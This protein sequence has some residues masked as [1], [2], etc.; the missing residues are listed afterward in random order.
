MLSK[1][2]YSLRILKRNK[3]IL[4]VNIVGLWVGLAVCLLLWVYID[5][6]LSY[7]KHFKN[8]A[9][10]SRLITEWVE[11]DK[12]EVF[13]INLR[14]AYTE[15]PAGIP[16]VEA[17]VQLYRSWET[18]IKVNESNFANLKMLYAD[19]TFFKVFDA[20]FVYGSENKPFKGS[21]SAII[22]T[23]LA[24]KAFGD[25][26]PLGK[27]IRIDN[28]D[29]QVSG[30]IKDFPATTHFNFQVLLPMQATENLL[31]LGGL[32]FYTYYLYAPNTN[33]L[34]VS[35]KI[36]SRYNKQLDDRFGEF[37][38]EF[39]SYIEPLEQ[40]HLFTKAE[41]DLSP[42]GNL[43]QVFLVALISFII[44]FMA[45]F[46]CVNLY[47]VFG[48]NRSKELG[49][50]KISGASSKSIKWQMLFE[51][52]IINGIALVL[53]LVLFYFVAPYFGNL[54]QRPI[55]F[56]A[57]FSLSGM[58]ALVFILFFSTALSG[59]YPAFV[60]SKFNSI[61]ILSGTVAKQKI[62]KWLSPSIV[63]GQFGMVVLL[64]FCLFSIND[65]LNF[66]KQMPLGFNPRNV[67]AFSGFN[68]NIYKQA[69]SL[70]ND[71]KNLPGVE[72][73]G[74]S[75]HTMGSGA[76]GQAIKKFGNETGSEISIDEFRVQPGFCKTYDL[77][78]VWG[79]FFK[80]NE[81]GNESVVILNRTA[82]ERLGIDNREN[83]RVDMFEFPMEVVGVVEDFM[84]HGANQVVQPMVLCCRDSSFWNINIRLNAFGG[85]DTRNQVIAIIQKYD[86][87]YIPT[88]SF[89]SER[90]DSFYAS[91][92]RTTQIVGFGS[93]VAIL[94]SLMGLFAITVY[95]IHRKYKE[96][97]IRKVLGAS[98]LKIAHL[99]LL[100]LGYWML[101][102]VLFA[103]PIG[104]LIIKR[105][106]SQYPAHAELNFAFFIL[107]ALLPLL[108]A[109]LTIGWHV[110][111]V[112]RHNPVESLRYE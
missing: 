24:Q 64:L 96:L 100:N 16:E 30:V 36:T 32:E 49:I 65:Q 19:T 109:L 23:S 52:L 48:Q 47:M 8:S 73:M 4:T 68:S 39:S 3:L 58:L 106:F 21:L 28:R 60:L 97:G 66:L 26:N 71:L 42:I 27:I 57:V 18:K 75:Q 99:V 63:I 7:D 76:S 22:T 33:H 12:K 69:Q 86:P 10:I 72:Q 53:A 93:L 59:L 84:Y 105:W 90:F 46:N 35:D 55:A 112:A 31:Y 95:N 89:I 103:W 81:L 111:K 101:I 88:Y 54:I 94:I 44:L 104:T 41:F 107:S 51:A 62:N 67:V 70:Q 50:R 102:A 29:F 13:P 38:A 85:S 92:K 43:K 61:E 56:N 98:S 91:E 78:L 83:N 17:S 45:I 87:D 20:S 110:L 5:H 80:P 77:K 34:D 108:L 11:G 2:K 82:A 74:F 79:R 25:T 14:T 6:E 40:I 1:L 9:R 37:K 15:I